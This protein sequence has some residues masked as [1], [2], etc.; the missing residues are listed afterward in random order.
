MAAAVPVLALFVLWERRKAHAD[1][2]PLV[3]LGLFGQRGFLAGLGVSLLMLSGI[4]GFFLVYVLYVQTGLGFSTL[5]AALVPMPWPVGIALAAGIAARLATRLG[6]RLITV[7]SLL[8]AAGM[9]ALVWTTHRYGAGIHAWQLL[10]PL[11]VGGLGMGLM[12]YFREPGAAVLAALD[13]A[14]VV[15]RQACHRRMSGSTPGR[16]SSRRVTTSAGP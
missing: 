3:A 14:E 10:L 12:F 6:R 16:S 2:A 8:V 13:M 15:G 7:G 1:G 9:A 5:K 4:T 11:A